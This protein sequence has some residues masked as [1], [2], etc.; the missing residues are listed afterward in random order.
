MSKEISRRRALTLA[1]S[2]LA[3]SSATPAQSPSRWATKPQQDAFRGLRVGITTFSTGQLSLD[4]TIALLRTLDV[5]HISLKSFHLALESRAPERAAVKRKIADGGLT[6]L[7]CGLIELPPDEPGMRAWF[8]YARDIG[9]ETMVVKVQQP[10]LKLVDRLVREYP[11]IRVALHT[12]GPEKDDPWAW[13]SAYR[14]LE[15][16]GPLHERIGCC[17]DTGHTFRVP[18]DPAEAIRACGDRLFEVHLKDVAQATRERVDSPL[19]R[20]VIDIVSVLQALVDV[21]FGGHV[22]LEN[23]IDP[24]D[25]RVVIAESFGYVRGVTA[26]LG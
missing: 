2:G 5:R 7:G 8:E 18:I 11:G 9:A 13:A 3:A 14:I 22:A 23:H 24:E 25:P 15:E 21:E 17:V 6:L 20:G 4:E 26:Q 16:I 12:H 10:S 1:A 19:G